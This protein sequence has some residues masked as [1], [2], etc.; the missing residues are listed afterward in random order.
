MPKYKV[1]IIVIIVL[2]LYTVSLVALGM[3][4][5]DIVERQYKARQTFVVKPPDGVLRVCRGQIQ[6]WSAISE[7]WVCCDSWF[8]YKA[9][10]AA[11]ED[12]ETN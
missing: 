9:K 5:V 8:E 10:R 6:F 2:C 3:H 4:M 12:K 7:K 11:R 1:F